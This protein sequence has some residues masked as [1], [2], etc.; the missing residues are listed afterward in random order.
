MRSHP[1][2][3]LSALA[4]AGY[5]LCCGPWAARAEPPVRATEA[6][7]PALVIVAKQ[8]L[9]VGVTTTVEVIVRPTR[10]GEQPLLLTPTTEGDAVR[11]VRGRLSRTD[12]TRGPDGALHFAVPI[13]ARA[14]GTAVLRVELL[15]YRC[16]ERCVALHLSATR[17]LQVAGP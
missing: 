12:A 2:R 10:G 13:V 5:A 6:A 14:P 9:R 15:T 7:A 4:A 1:L 8:G 16:A 17:I 11:V 3:I